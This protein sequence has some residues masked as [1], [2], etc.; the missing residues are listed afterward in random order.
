MAVAAAGGG[1][2]I[3]AA[4]AAPAYASAPAA[5]HGGHKITITAHPRAGAGRIGPH[6]ILP[7]V[8]KPGSGIKPASCGQQTISCEI[9]AGTPQVAVDSGVVLGDAWVTCSSVVTSISLNEELLHNGGSAGG[10]NDFQPNDAGAFTV[11][12]ATCQPGTWANLAEALI[13]FPPGYVLTGGTNPIHQTSASI[14]VSSTGCTPNSG[15]GGGSGGGGCA[16]HATSLASHPAG[17]HPH[18]IACP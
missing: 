15:G 16:V 11:A 10:D 9:T 6:T 18:V 12:E 14:Q 8:A 4:G 1:L 3:A 17:R 5:P 2:L 7:C 13:T